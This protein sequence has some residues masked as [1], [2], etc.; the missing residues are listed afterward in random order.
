[1]GGCPY[2]F[3]WC[4]SWRQKGA[5]SEF[6]PHTARSLSARVF[7]IDSLRFLAL[8]EDCPPQLLISI[9]FPLFSL[10]H[11]LLPIP[12]PTQVPTPIYLQ[13]LF[14]F[15]FWERVNH[16]CYLSSFDLWIIVWLSCSLWLIFTYK[17]IHTMHL[18]LGLDC[19][20]QDDIF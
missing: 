12:S 14:Y 17:W 10:H 5:T 16:L 11:A 7:P 8:P 19:L 2:P 15:S 3:I 4:L 18:I 6:V 1:M 20:I 13:Y 9:L